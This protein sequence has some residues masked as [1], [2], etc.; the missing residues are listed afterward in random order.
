MA[1]DTLQGADWG[2]AGNWASGAVPVA[3]DAVS[4][5]A[6]LNVNVTDSGGAAETID[7]DLV[8]VTPGFNHLFGTSGAPIRFAADRIEVGGSSGFYFESDADTSGTPLITDLIEV[9]CPNANTP[10]EIGSYD[11]NSTANRGVITKIVI[12]R[13][14]VLLKGNIIFNSSEVILNP[15]SPGDARLEIASGA[16][17]L[18]ELDIRG[19]ESIA[20]NVLT[21]IKI[22]R[23]AK[24]TQDTAAI[25]TAEVYG[26]LLVN[27]G[28]GL[29]GTTVATTI[30]MYKGSTVNLFGDGTKAGLAK[31]VTTIVKHPDSTLIYDSSLHTISTLEVRGI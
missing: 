11:S 17:T 23:G 5:P 1:L 28:A 2:T 15:T 13:G 14:N 29:A 9:L 10:V 26:T 6:T 4:I 21:E 31:T 3:N 7:L 16:D 8:K 25:T 19:G 27:Y 22:A 24:H 20:H 18:E 12:S 30:R